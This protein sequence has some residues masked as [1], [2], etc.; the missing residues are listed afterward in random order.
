[1]SDRPAILAANTAFYRAFEKKDIE[2]LAAV[3]SQGTDTT[4]V[5][6]GRKALTGWQSIRYSWQQIFRATQYLELE[7]EVLSVEENGDLA[8][9]VLVETVLQV[10]RG[11]RMKAESMATNVFQRMGDRWFLIHHHGSPIMQ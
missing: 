8:V 9:V 3:C 2:A 6:P 7:T 1:M 11:R 4:C 10:G 5:H